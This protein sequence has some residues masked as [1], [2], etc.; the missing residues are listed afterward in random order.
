[1]W[2]DTVCTLIVFYP[3]R[4]KAPMMATLRSQ[5]GDIHIPDNISFYEFVSSQFENNASK[6]AL[7]SSTD[8]SH[9][10]IINIIM[11]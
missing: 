4:N 9:F 7:V 2:A 6:P 3:L 11:T 1:M 8:I 10:Y 5:Y